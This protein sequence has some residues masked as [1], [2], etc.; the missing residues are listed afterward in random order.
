MF[1][2]FAW[3]AADPTAARR[4]RPAAKRVDA[5]LAPLL[6][7]THTRRVIG[8]S[9]WGMTVCH[10][11]QGQFRWPTFVEDADVAAVSLGIPV[12]S[13]ATGG[14]L[15]MA[16]RLLRGDD[17]HADVV[18]PFGLIACDATAAGRGDDDHADSPRADRDTPPS[19]DRADTD[20]VVLQQDWLGHCRLFTGSGEGITA[21][22]NRPTLLAKFLTRKSSPSPDGWASYTV[23]GH[24]GGSTSPVEGVRLLHPG[25][26][27]VCRRGPDA[28]TV[29]DGS[30]G[31]WI[32]EHD[33]RFCADDVV[34]RGLD[35]RQS[36]SDVAL[37]RAASALKDV[38]SGLGDLYDDRIAL[39]LSG[40]WDSRLIAAAFLAAGQMPTLRTHDDTPA[41]ADVARH[42][43]SIINST[44]GVRPVHE[45][46]PAG[47][48]GNVLAVGLRDRAV[49]L[50]QQYDCQFPSTY[51][52]RPA[53]PER[54]PGSLGSLSVTG[55]AGELATGYWYPGTDDESTETVRRAVRQH[56][57]SAVP[58]GAA[59]ADV[60]VSERARL[61]AL[62]DHAATL[63]LIGVEQIDY[64]YLMERMRRWS[65]SA[66]KVGMVVPFLAPDVV[67]ATFALTAAD[68][69]ARRL[70]TGLLRRFVP[71]WS[72]V[73]YVSISTGRST[74]TAIW[75]GDGL[76]AVRRLFY[77]TESNGIAGL[78][79]PNAVYRALTECTDGH[80]SAAHRRTL[81]QFVALAVASRGL[82]PATGRPVL[83]A[84]VRRVRREGVI[85]LQTRA[86]ASVARRASALTRRATRTPAAPDPAHDPTASAT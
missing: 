21:F 41:E 23:A 39:G 57:L 60:I 15:A 85:P 29:D 12:G 75:D 78:V 80:Y 18:P 73:P 69:R 52:V 66:Y 68:K 55:A 58:P 3:F 44:R 61:D 13:A 24:F 84:T 25:E 17:V 86:A 82:D 56:L 1:V 5:A 77:G 8:A 79:R 9:C 6:S 37:D 34:R 62:V 50:A 7:A 11:D 10:P 48:P 42:L 31:G 19:G 83:M 38:V 32:V 67:A 53:A 74:A 63:G 47:A 22:S 2:V 27:V 28:G 33:R 64:A 20:R 51:L 54:L 49:R 65:T 71:E 81:Q 30:A 16:R 4:A 35:D 70:H 26:R 43:V 36:G 59:R 76:D 14:P 45:I 72:D 40:G 46:G